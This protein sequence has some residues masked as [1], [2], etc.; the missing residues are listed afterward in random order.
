MAKFTITLND[1]PDGN[2]RVDRA[3]AL[4]PD[5]ELDGPLT[6][7]AILYLAIDEL[8]DGDHGELIHTLYRGRLER[9]QIEAEAHGI[10]IPAADR[11]EAEMAVHVDVSD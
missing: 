5:A 8:T 11:P 2:V 10:I 1:L 4:I 9:M 6:P 3:R 7:A